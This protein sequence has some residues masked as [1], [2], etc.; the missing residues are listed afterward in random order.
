MMLGNGS[1]P[2]VPV[3]QEI[4]R[5]KNWYTYNANTILFFTFNTVLNKLQKIFNTSY[6]IGFVLDYFEQM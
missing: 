1:Q 3:S 6:K 2:Q 4:M 5:I